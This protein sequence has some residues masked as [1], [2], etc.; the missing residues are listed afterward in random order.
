MRLG[1][2]ELKSNLFLNSVRGKLARLLDEFR[3]SSMKE[4]LGNALGTR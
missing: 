4:V 2:L 1:S 3:F